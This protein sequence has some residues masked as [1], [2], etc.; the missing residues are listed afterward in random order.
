MSV[1][2]EPYPTYNESL[3]AGDKSDISTSEPAR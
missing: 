2:V 3:R 1:L